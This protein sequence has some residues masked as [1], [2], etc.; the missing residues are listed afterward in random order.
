MSGRV[1]P[2]PVEEIVRVRKSAERIIEI[3]RDVSEEDE[4]SIAID[5]LNQVLEVM[6]VEGADDDEDDMPFEGQDTAC[7][8]SVA[9]RL[10]Y[11]GPDRV[12]IQY[13]TKE[14]ARH[15]ASPRASHEGGLKK[16]GKYSGAD[17]D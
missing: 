5:E 7:C 2:K 14:A 8:R 13:A 11:I 16:T 1:E 4:S 15:M 6:A 10:H 3:Q 9:A 17:R 12:D